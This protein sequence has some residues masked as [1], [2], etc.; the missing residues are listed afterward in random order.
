MKYLTTNA[1]T[2][3]CLYIEKCLL[4]VDLTFSRNV[5]QK[6]GVDYTY[7]TFSD[8]YLERKS[9]KKIF[10]FSTNFVTQES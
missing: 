4:T 5:K 7:D 1:H 2:N 6:Q 10:I 3:V 9:K 8:A